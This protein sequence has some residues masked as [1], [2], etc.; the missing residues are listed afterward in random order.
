LSRASREEA[1]KLYAEMVE[2][3]VA[4]FTAVSHYFAG[5]A[6]I[7]ST[8]QSDEESEGFRKAAPVFERALEQLAIVNECEGRML[9][10]A[11]PIEYSAYYVRRHQVARH[12]TEDFRRGLELMVKDLSDGYYPLK[13]FSMLNPV[14]SRLMAGW[15]LNARVEGMITRL[16]RAQSKTT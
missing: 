9:K 15:D 16:E 4:M 1:D 6:Q 3:D 14:L 8:K 5:V 13:A 7:H 12:G 10:I 11:E 2:A